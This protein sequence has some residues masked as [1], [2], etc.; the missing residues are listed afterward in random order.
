LDVEVERKTRKA[1]ETEK[2]SL[3]TMLDHLKVILNIELN[4]SDELKRQR[5]EVL[6]QMEKACRGK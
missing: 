3:G 4:K 2:A 1:I 6:C 5:D